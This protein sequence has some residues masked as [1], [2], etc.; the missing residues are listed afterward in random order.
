MA[1]IFNTFLQLEVSKRACAAGMDN[2][3]RDT[4]VVETVNLTGQSEY[5]AVQYTIQYLTYLFSGN[6]ILQQRRTSPLSIHGLEPI[7]GIFHSGA[8]I[9]GNRLFC[10]DIGSVGFE[11]DHF[12][13]LR[14]GILQH[15]LGFV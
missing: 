4:L 3:L 9:S 2:S 8:M 10:V 12:L 7:V 6:L 14:C 11:I 5:T 1:E 15:L 13:I